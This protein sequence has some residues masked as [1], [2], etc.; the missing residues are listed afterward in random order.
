LAHGFGFASVLGDLTGGISNLAIALGGFNLGVEFGQLGLIMI[1]F[2]LLYALAHIRSYQR[3][4]VP[5]ILLGV[6]IISLTW[7]V[8][9][10]SMI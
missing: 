8:E 6:G 9:R 7:A 2:P 5:L 10:A 4:V 1:G 3:V